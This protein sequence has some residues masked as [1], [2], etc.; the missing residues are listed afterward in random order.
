M[1][2]Q[3]TLDRIAINLAI[4]WKIFVF[5][6]EMILNISSVFMTPQECNYLL[7]L[8][9][10]IDNRIFPDI[11]TIYLFFPSAVS[12]FTSSNMIWKEV[13]HCSPVLGSKGYIRIQ[14]SPPT[15]TFD[16]WRKISV[17]FL[18]QGD[19]FSHAFNISLLK[20]VS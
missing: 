3:W 7:L 16:M 5:L 12:T 2:N 10:I 17:K 20:R 14:H 1:P 8:K 19:P 11:V 6:V 15:T 13:I 18:K 9:F 4:R